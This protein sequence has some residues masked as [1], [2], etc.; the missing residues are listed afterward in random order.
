MDTPPDIGI[1]TDK[2]RWWVAA[3]A[4]TRLTVVDWLLVFSLPL[5][6]IGGVALL[7]WRD[8]KLGYAL[9]PCFFHTVTGLWCIGCGATRSVSALLHGRVL[10]AISYNAWMLFWLPWPVYAALRAW[11][12]RV[13]LKRLRLPALPETGC[14]LWALL[15]SALTFMALRNL[16]WHPFSWLAP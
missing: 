11:L 1:A 2:A 3:P 8:P 6:A 7:Y 13:T 5:A 14:F 4:D 16:P 12:W 15:I 9:M 10:E